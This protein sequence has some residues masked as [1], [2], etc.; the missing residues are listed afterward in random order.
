MTKFNNH[1]NRETSRTNMESP[2]R[3]P[4]LKVTNEVHQQVRHNGK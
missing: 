1:Q 2:S 4:L 3:Q